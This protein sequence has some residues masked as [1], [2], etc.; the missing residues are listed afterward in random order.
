MSS[1]PSVASTPPLS[2]ADPS[3]ATDPSADL[4]APICPRTGRRL[5]RTGTL[6]Y[7]SAGLVAL[8]AWLL[9]GDF[10]WNMKERAIVP[11][12]QLMLRQFGASDFFIGLMVGSVPAAIGLVLG[13]LISV[14]SDRHRGRWGRRIPYLLVPTPII[15]LSMAG[16]AFTVPLAECLHGWLGASSPGEIGCRLLVFSFFWAT[17][18]IFQTIAQAVFGGLI[19]DVVPQEVIGRFYGLFR[20]V[21]LVAAIL[22]NFWLIDHAETHFLKIFLGLGLLYGV[23]FTLMCLRVKEGHYP[24]PPPLPPASGPGARFGGALRAYLRDCYAHPYYL[25]VFGALMLGGL[26]GG[27][28]NAFSVFYAK[29]VGL[30]MNAYGHLLVITYLCSLASSYFLGSLADRFHP[31]RL[32][33]VA[34][35]A[36]ALAMLW[37]AVAATDA[38]IF[39]VFFVTHGVIQGVYNTGMA[40]IGQRLFPRAKFAQFASAAG[41]PGALAFMVMN[42]VL[43]KYLD[44]NGHVYRHTFLWSGVIAVAALAALWVVWRKFQALGGP[45]AYTPPD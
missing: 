11:L 45:R 8:F 24:P 33:L 41:I 36:Y 2:A 23:G 7:T 37:G 39:S 22:F 31:L 16:L 26:A 21:S 9:W 1:P 43:G 4:G 5:W 27:P 13:P 17:F 18:E 38:K 3:S 6:T 29:S 14:R 34:L 12:G 19:N 10:A 40:S 28:V 35:G 42:P 15:A 30:D 25:W 32:G 44:L 20:A